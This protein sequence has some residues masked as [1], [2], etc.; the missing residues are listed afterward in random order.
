MTNKLSNFEESIKE[1][2]ENH[3][4]P[5]N[6]EHWDELEKNLDKVSEGAAVAGYSVG[7]SVF[8]GAAVL[9]IL[10]GVYLY[11]PKTSN[12]KEIFSTEKSVE[13]NNLSDSNDIQNNSK[14]D[15]NFSVFP[16]GEEVVVSE[17]NNNT[18]N[19]TNKTENNNKNKVSKKDK[20][21]SK[22]EIESE[23]KNN[24]KKTDKI[25]KSGVIVSKDLTKFSINTRKGCQGLSIQFK[26]DNPDVKAN[27]L[28]NFGDGFFSNE[29]NPTHSFNKTGLFDVSISVTSSA[30]GKISS[31]TI[32]N[33]V[34]IEAAPNANFEIIKSEKTAGSIDF[35]NSSQEALTYDWDFG[36]GKSS[37]ETNPEHFYK[38]KGEFIVKL[39]ASNKGGC[40]DSFTKKIYIENE[41][42]L[43]AAGIFYPNKNEKFMPSDLLDLKNYKSFALQVYDATSGIIIFESTKS[44]QPWNGKLKNGE[45]VPAGNY[46]W[47]VTQKLRDG[48]S[49]I[50]KG[51]VEIK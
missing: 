50:Y 51:V 29:P 31:N 14:K 46:P 39:V 5:Y 26:L 13:L 3:E 22:K 21:L 16:K 41:Y 18:I 8:S 25:E 11:Y 33:M 15:S 1:S 28:W 27:Y 20:I 37:K 34:E 48:N 47:F 6:Q 45:T 24:L 23:L 38:E 2:L 32:A 30:N 4:V 40:S 10:A 35:T 12:V 7:W 44:T 17:N 9:A 42:N 43:N 19:S 36:D 49:E